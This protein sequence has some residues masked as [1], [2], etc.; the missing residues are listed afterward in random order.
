MLLLSGKGDIW[1]GAA[2][3]FLMAQTL[4]SH[5]LHVERVTPDT[6]SI[7]WGK[8][9]RAWE[10]MKRGKI[11]LGH[12]QAQTTR[13]LRDDCLLSNHHGTTTH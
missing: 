12:V 5:E 7:A 4:D 2:E 11:C 9:R 8:Q 6:S 1:E 10:K 3:T 13:H